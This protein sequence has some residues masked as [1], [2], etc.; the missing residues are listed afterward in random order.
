MYRDNHPLPQQR[1]PGKAKYEKIDKSN[2]Q[3]ARMA[4]RQIYP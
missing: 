2:V 3:K 4:D 1:R